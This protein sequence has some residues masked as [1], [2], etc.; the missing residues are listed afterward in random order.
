LEGISHRSNTLLL[1][2]FNIDLSKD[3]AYWWWWWWWWWW[4]SGVVMTTH[5]ILGPQVA[6]SGMA[7]R[8]RG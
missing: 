7:S 4:C 5:M 3:G 8:Y 2:D 1:G 6:D